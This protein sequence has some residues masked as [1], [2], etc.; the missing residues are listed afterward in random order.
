ML[1][2]CVHKGVSVLA[3]GVFNSGLLAVDH[4]GPDARYNYGRVPA[5]V[6]ARVRRIGEICARHGVPVP[7]A[8]MAF[9]ASHPAV[10]SV[11][12]GTRSAGEITRNAELFGKPAPAEL[13]PDLVDAG[14]LRPDAPVP[15]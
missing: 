3:A 9:V 15:T 5:E 8:A 14:L 12:V 10:S 13:W 1:P 6:H 4:P 11:L 7:Q 2:L